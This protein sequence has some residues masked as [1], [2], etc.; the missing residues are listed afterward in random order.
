MYF[1]RLFQ[2]TNMV[3]QNRF[4]KADHDQS[5]TNMFNNFAFKKKN[6]KL[7]WRKI[8]NL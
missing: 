7:D 3:A 8:G 5:I 4:N 1:N 2:N 6:E